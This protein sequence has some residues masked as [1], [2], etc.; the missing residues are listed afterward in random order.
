MYRLVIRPPQPDFRLYAVPQEIKVANANEV[1]LT[2]LALRRGGTTLLRVGAERIDG[3][4]EPIE[5]DVEGIPEGV[6]CETGWL[7]ADQQTLWLVLRA[8]EDVEAWAGRFKSWGGPRRGIR[9]W[10]AVRDRG[11]SLGARPM[12]HRPGLNSGWLGN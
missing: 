6:H 1:R 7:G 11:L 8:D 9:P 10:F 5:V 12:S 3:F 2:S 4:A